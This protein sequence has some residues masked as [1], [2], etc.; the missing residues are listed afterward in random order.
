MNLIFLVHFIVF[1]VVQQNKG[2]AFKLTPFILRD[3]IIIHVILM[4]HQNSSYLMFMSL[5]I[6]FYIIMQATKALRI[7]SRVV[8]WEHTIRIPSCV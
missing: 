1:E 4:A 8:E 3:L 5:I 2:D 7:Y 6:Q